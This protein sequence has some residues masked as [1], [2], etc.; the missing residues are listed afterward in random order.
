[1]KDKIIKEVKEDIIKNN[2]KYPFI[3]RFWDFEVSE[4]QEKQKTYLNY[5]HYGTKLLDSIPFK[6]P[7]SKIIDP[8]VL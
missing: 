2:E 1:M 8:S 5:G 4:L 6:K 7:I 3:A